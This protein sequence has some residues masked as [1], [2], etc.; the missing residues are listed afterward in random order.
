MRST[1]PRVLT[2]LEAVALAVVC[3]RMVPGSVETGA[4]DYIDRL[5]RALPA[6]A[7]R[8]LR[9]SIAA[10]ASASHDEER[11]AALAT[12]P[13][14]GAVRRLVIEAYYGDYAPEGHAGP[15]GWQAIGFDAPQALRLAK[16][17]SFL[18]ERASR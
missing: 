5:A 7:L 13:A 17:W 18:D 12:T 2:D 14:F 16:D 4:V 1:V 10:L 15:T 9:A 8:D 11:F 6:A 3:D